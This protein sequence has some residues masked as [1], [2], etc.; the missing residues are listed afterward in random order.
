MEVSGGEAT[1]AERGPGPRIIVTMKRIPSDIDRTALDADKEVELEDL[2]WELLLLLDGAR[3]LLF[4]KE[5][6]SY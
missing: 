6:L 2:R 5:W 1:N 4:I 3:P